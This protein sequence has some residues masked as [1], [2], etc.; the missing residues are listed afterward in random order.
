[1]AGFFIWLPLMKVHCHWRRTCPGLVHCELRQ[2]CLNI[3]MLMDVDC[4][5]LLIALDD[6]GKI[7][8]DTPKIMYPEILLHLILDL[9]NQALINNDKEVIDILTIC[10]EDWALMLKHK[11]YSIDM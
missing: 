11:Q 4:V 2:G 10:S 1:M 6:H 7:Q 3:A 5:M 8:G 9:P